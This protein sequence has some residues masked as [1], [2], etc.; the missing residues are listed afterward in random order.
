MGN[1]LLT[2]IYFKIIFEQNDLSFIINIKCLKA[3]NENNTNNSS[4]DEE[5]SEEEE[6]VIKQTENNRMK[7]RLDWIRKM[8]PLMKIP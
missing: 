8:K 6:E 7:M 5:T 4:T 3:R 1:Y 2:L